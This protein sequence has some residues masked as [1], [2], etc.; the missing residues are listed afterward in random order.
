MMPG[1]TRFVM[2]IDG[3]GSH[4]K[5]WLAT[6]KGKILGKGQAGASNYQSV[7]EAAAKN[8][9]WHTIQDA[10]TQAGQPMRKLDCL[11][12]GLAGF[13]RDSEQRLIIE[14]ADEADLAH[15][16]VVVNDADLLLWAGTPDRWGI[17]LVCGTGSI[18]VGRTIDGIIARA[19]GWGYLIGDEGSGYALGL[20]AL[21]AAVKS[22]DGRI[23]PTQL[24]EGILAFF[25]LT[26]VEEL[27]AYLYQNRPSREAIAQLAEVVFSAAEKGDQQANLILE[28][29]AIELALAVQAVN[30][31]LGW[32]GPVPC[33]LG[34]GVFLHNP[35]FVHRVLKSSK[36]G[37]L[38][39]EPVQLVAEPAIGAVRLAIYTLKS[40]R[41]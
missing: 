30:S 27:V 32:Q 40:N 26:Q 20:A 13:G 6:T 15:R 36:E 11:V 10:F 1:K 29:A 5:A 34:G 21:Q 39:L 35:A 31:T 28:S 12:M 7:G 23:L 4:T 8:A 3:G 19:G 25:E 2:G 14:W 37:G 33:A 18:A 38:Q 17:S 41:I 9:L 16:V 22:A 24:L